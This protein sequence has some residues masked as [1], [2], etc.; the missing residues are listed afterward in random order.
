[1]DES[2]P[3]LALLGIDWAFNINVVLNLKKNKMSFET[4]MLHMVSPLDPYEDDRYNELV[5]EDV[6]ISVIEN[7]YRITGYREEYINPTLDGELSWLS[8]KSY[9][10]YSKDALERWKNK[11][12]EV[13][14]R[15]CTHISP[16]ECEDEFGSYW[17]DGLEP[18]NTFISWIQ[19]I[20]K[21]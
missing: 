3:Y 5:D 8:V 9:D 17:Y 13:S 14:T 19:C 6:E 2:D 21:H 16:K 18:V 7:I 10:I 4:D 11:L 12:Y 1:M 15:R 20:L